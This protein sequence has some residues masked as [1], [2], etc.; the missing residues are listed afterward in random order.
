MTNSQEEFV[1]SAEGVTFETLWKENSHF[2]TPRMLH[3][4]WNWLYL[5]YG[6][7]EI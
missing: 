1:A 4:K 7:W 5:F 3:Y 2:Q 6:Q